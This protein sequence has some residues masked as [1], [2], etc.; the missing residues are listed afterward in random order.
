LVISCILRILQ[1]PFTRLIV[2][3]SHL[4]NAVLYFDGYH[5]F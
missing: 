4:W 5:H 2:A 1:D 3:V